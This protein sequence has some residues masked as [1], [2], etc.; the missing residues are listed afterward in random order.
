MNFI[1]K[2]GT[3]R[4]TSSLGMTA[5]CSWPS[6]EA[7]TV[8]PLYNVHSGTS[9]KCTLIRGVRCMESHFKQ[10]GYVGTCLYA[11]L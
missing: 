6:H 1:R 11:T 2:V 5:Q 3:A 9:M 7:Y 8:K 10:S 4:S